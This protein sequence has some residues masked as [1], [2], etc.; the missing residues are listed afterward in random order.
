MAPILFMLETPIFQ[1]G[2]K[3]WLT[4][5]RVNMVRNTSTLAGQSETQAIKTSFGWRYST[6]HLA[7]VLNTWCSKKA[8][9]T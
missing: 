1:D 4:T 7:F 5:D 3:G 2:S 8:P 6:V 9:Q